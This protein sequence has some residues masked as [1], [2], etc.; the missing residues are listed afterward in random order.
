MKANRVLHEAKCNHDVNITIRSIPAQNFR[1]MAFSDASFSSVKKPDSDAGSIIMGTYQDIN[2]GFECPISPLTW[3]WR[4]IQK[5]ITNTL[6]AETMALATTLD[7]LSWLRLFWSWMHDPRENWKK[8]E[9]TLPK[10]EPVITVPPLILENNVAITD[11]NNQ[12]GSSQ[13]FWVSGSINN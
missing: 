10:L 11:C 5:V 12:D 6:S 13:L 3:G 2:Q 8:P 7:Q 4:R 1:L 9:R